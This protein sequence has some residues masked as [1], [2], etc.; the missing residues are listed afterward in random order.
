MNGIDPQPRAAMM[1]VG[2]LGRAINGRAHGEAARFSGV[3]TDT[4]TLAA[5][6]LFVAL[7]GERFDGHA[8]VVEAFK[9]GAAAALVSRE[10]PGA[11]AMPHVVVDDTRLALGRLAADWRAR[12]AMPVVALTGSNGKTTV[13]EMLAAILA[14]NSGVREAVLATEGN[15]NNDIGMPLTLLGLREHHHYAVIEMGMNHAGEIDYLTR[16]AQPTVALVNNAQRAHVGILG[17]VAAIARAK[18]IGRASC[19]ER[20]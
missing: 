7:K 10:V 2:Q 17:S 19:R 5:G 4:R 8:Y 11:G 14:S 12:F 18:E 9:R 15:L 16:I 13:K 6:D 1:D 20:V 3:A